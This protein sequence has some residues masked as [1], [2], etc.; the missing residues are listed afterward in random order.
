MCASQSGA[1]IALALDFDG[2][3][4][5]GLGVLVLG[6][7]AA[8]GAQF[9]R[10]QQPLVLG[11][12]LARLR[13]AA[14][15]EIGGGAL[16]GDLQHHALGGGHGAAGG[17]F[18]DDAS[19]CEFGRAKT[20]SRS[21]AQARRLHAARCDLVACL[22]AAGAVGIDLDLADVVGAPAGHA[23]ARLDLGLVDLPCDGV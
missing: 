1:A 11:L 8:V 22:G 20:L 4:R 6:G 15:F 2:H 12:G 23:A 19:A 17:V 3:H 5:V 16:G 13:G 14:Q 18:H 9:A 7:S 10:S 21:S